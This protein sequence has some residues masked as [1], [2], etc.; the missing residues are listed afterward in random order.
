MLI[1]S[2]IAAAHCTVDDVI[3]DEQCTDTDLCFGP[4]TEIPKAIQGIVMHCLNSPEKFVEK[5]ELEKPNMK[6]IHAVA[7]N[8][9]SMREI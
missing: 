9:T 2:L 6:L 4:G 8:A 5:I 1:C 7:H 3:C